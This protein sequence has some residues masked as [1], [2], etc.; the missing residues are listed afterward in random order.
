MLQ[1]EFEKLI[2]RKVTTEE[3]RAAETAYMQTDMTKEEFCAAYNKSDRALVDTLAESAKFFNTA[4]NKEFSEFNSFKEKMLEMAVTSN[5]KAMVEECKAVMS[6]QAY[7]TILIRMDK[8]SLLTEDEKN[9]LIGM[10]T[11]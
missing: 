8:T 10:I 6:F 1:Q 3:F 7:A 5:N 11:K 4:F 2:G 9:R